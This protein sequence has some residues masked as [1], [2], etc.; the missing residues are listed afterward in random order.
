MFRYYNIWIIKLLKR[1]GEI[2]R[3][4][5]D[6]F[7][8]AKME[9]VIYSSILRSTWSRWILKSIY[10]IKKLGI[11]SKYKYPYILALNINRWVEE[12]MDWNWYHMQA[13][14]TTIKSK[15]SPLMYFAF[16]RQFYIGIRMTGFKNFNKMD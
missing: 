11:F 7:V 16:L 8:F 2:A 15:L 13:H 1:R 6:L 3:N 12:R 4:R 5:M 9:E 10:H 14:T